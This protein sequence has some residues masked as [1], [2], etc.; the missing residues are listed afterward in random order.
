MGPLG[1]KKSDTTEQLSLHF[2]SFWI[3]FSEI[4]CAN[5]P[6]PAL[7]RDVRTSVDPSVHLIPPLHLLRAVQAGGSLRLVQ[8]KAGLCSASLPPCLPKGPHSALTF[9]AASSLAFPST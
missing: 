6:A 4:Y 2:T 9:P 8:Q 3:Q 1:C 7:L 5:D